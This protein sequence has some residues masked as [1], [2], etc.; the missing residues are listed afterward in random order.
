MFDVEG[1]NAH[2]KAQRKDKQMGPA[3][4]TCWNREAMAA[5]TMLPT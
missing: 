1:A 2:N 4:K 3:D 5:Q